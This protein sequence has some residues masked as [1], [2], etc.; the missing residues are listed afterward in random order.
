[1]QGVTSCPVRCPAAVAGHF[2]GRI[3]AGNGLSALVEYATEVSG[4]GCR[5]GHVR[6]KYPGAAGGSCQSL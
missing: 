2:P 6:D 4:V 1:M 3:R 5:Y